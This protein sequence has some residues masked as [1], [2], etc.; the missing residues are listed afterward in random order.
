MLESEFLVRVLTAS[1]NPGADG[2]RAGCGMSL[3]P[4]F[5]SGRG[6]TRTD[7]SSATLE[8]V[9][10]AIERNVGPK[11]AMAF[12]RMVRDIKVL[13]ATNFLLALQRLEAAEWRWNRSMA[14]GL[15]GVHCE[16]MADAF[17]TAVE[18]VGSANRPQVDE[19]ISIRW[20]F[21]SMHGLREPLAPK[22]NVYAYGN[23]QYI[24]VNGG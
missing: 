5:Y 16:D 23:S 18:I 10:E 2:K 24:T 15:T 8:V 22:T 3:R 6:A 9:F 17:C 4:A 1:G 20:D 11:A 14:S 21:L 13:S 7:L 19:T 12:A